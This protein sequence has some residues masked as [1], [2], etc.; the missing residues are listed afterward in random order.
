MTILEA[1]RGVLEGRGT[2]CLQDLYRELP[3]EKEHSIRA[4][5][6]ENLVKTFT[7]VAKGVYAMRKGEA[8][9]V[10]VN[11]DAWQEIRS[12]PT[13][14]IDAI[15]TDPPYP[16]LAPFDR[17][18]GK[19]RMQWTFEK[20][21][22][23]VKLGLEMMRVLKDGA[24]CLI[25]VPAENRETKPA[26]D[27]MLRKL[28]LCGLVFQ[29]KLIWDKQTMGMGYRG[30]SRYEGIVFL[31]KGARF[32][33]PCDLSITDVL[34]VR[35]IHASKRVH[36][37]EKPEGLLSTLI[38]FSTLVGETVLDMFAGS[39]ALGRAAVAI[40]RSAVL[41]EKDEAILNAA[42]VAR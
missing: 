21:E 39:C 22:I 18:G 40:G 24:H 17:T 14:S 3:D 13:A 37:C 23:D 15:V 4:R 26:I 2:I 38:R 8:V 31:S 30:R 7:R 32:R 11:G 1:I 36:P 20:R 6:Y 12:V 29:K 5:I 25:F 19:P 33:K 16:W 10:V 41:I 28:E 42:G 9:C 35:S 34:S 27:A